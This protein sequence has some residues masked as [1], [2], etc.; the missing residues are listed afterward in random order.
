MGHVGIDCF[1]IFTF[2]WLSWRENLSLSVFKG[3]RLSFLSTNFSWYWPRHS[4]FIVLKIFNWM[5]CQKRY[6][7]VIFTFTWLSWR[8]NL[9]LSVFKGKRLSFLSTNFSWYWPRH[10][11]FIVLKIFNWM[12]CQ[13]RYM[14]FWKNNAQFSISFMIKLLNDLSKNKD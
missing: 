12:S 10:S 8:E 4:P 7:I 9:S 3:K 2:T 1:Y 13:K 6:M 5:S 11:P 14:I